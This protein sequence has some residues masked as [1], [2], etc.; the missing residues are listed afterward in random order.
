METKAYIS[1]PCTENWETMK[2]GLHHRFCDNCSKNVIDFTSK[3]RRE[4]LE[5]LLLNLDQK[6]CGRVLPSQLDFT[7]HDYLVT[8]KA[9]S[10]QHN[11][12]NLTFYLLTLGTLILSGCDSKLDNENTKVSIQDFISTKTQKDTVN[13]AS[14]TKN[15][16]TKINKS[17]NQK[18]NTILLPEYQYLTG[19]LVVIAPLPFTD[20]PIEAIPDEPYEFVET[21]PEYIGGID[22]LTKFINENL[23]YPEWEKENKIQGIEFV[24]FIVDQ[25]GQVIEPKIIK[26]VEG[27]KNF[28]S[29]V[30]RII[31]MMPSW[32]AGQHNMQNVSVKF[33]LPI[34]F[35]LELH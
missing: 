22:E 8:I 35:E 13:L 15:A 27:S 12:T 6:V 7:P 14:I 18:K 32:Q 21:M 3:D 5:Y 4:I 9:L 10:K 31:K 17:K 34:K 25:N 1:K 19:D 11:N 29:E 20:E 33:N 26:T 30:L 2:I 24:S 23:K 28:D 16:S